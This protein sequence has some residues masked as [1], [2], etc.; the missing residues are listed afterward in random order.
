[1]GDYAPKRRPWQRK[2]GPCPECGSLRCRKPLKSFACW[3]RTYKEAMRAYDYVRCTGYGGLLRQAEVTLLD[4][5]QPAGNEVAY[6]P[7]WAVVMSK[8]FY[9][10]NRG[11]RQAQ[12]RSTLYARI[13]QD[14]RY[15]PPPPA[16]LTRLDE[17]RAFAALR[18]WSYSCG[19]W[20]PQA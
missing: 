3:V 6:A 20:S 10:E 1:V 2:G 14:P 15:G 13:R 7:G 17:L 9:E 11:R 18:G 4:A 5:P 12:P 19:M 16:L 8:T